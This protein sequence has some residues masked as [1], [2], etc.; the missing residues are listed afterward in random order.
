M[1]TNNPDGGHSDEL[2][3]MENK[4]SK[5]RSQVNSKLDN[6][7]HL[8]VILSAVE[9]NLQDQKTEKTPVAYFVSFCSLLDQSISNDFIV[10][11]GLA[12]ASSYFLD[13]VLPFT[14]KPL[15]VSKFG[16]ILAKL[17]VPITSSDAEAPLV[18]S[19]IGA[20]ES[21][22]LAQDYQRWTSNDSISPQRAMAGLLE[23]T[24]D[25]RPKVRRRAQEAVSS[26]LKNPPTSPNPMHPASTLCGKIALERLASILESNK[27][28]H[29][30]EVN[31]QIIHCLQ[32]IS[33]V[34]SSGSWP[35]KQIMPLCD[36]LLEVSKTNDQFIV[37][38]AFSAFEGLF[39][40]MNNVVN[41]ER[42]SQ[43]LDVIFD[44]KPAVNDLH[45]AASWLAV[46]AKASECFAALDAS[47]YITKFSNIFHQVAAFLSSESKD[48]YSS[49]SHCL[50]AITAAIPDEYLLQ[51][52]KQ[53]GISPEV[54]ESMDD[55]ISGLADTIEKDLLT[56]KHQHAFKEILEFINES[57][58]KLRS[59]AN[60]DLLGIVE[61][62]GDWRTTES[63][64]FS[65]NKEA[66][67]VLAS[68]ISVMGPEVV[69]GVLPLN[70][71]STT[72]PGRAWLL[73]LLRDNVRFANLGFYI[74]EILPL[75]EFF[76]EKISNL[77]KDSVNVKIFQT[78]IDQ[79][80]SLLPPFC[81]LP[82]DLTVAF[83]DSFA[84][85]LTEVLYSNVESRA[86]ICN[87]LRTLAESYITYS[88]EEL[89]KD[90]LAQE[91]LSI[92]QATVGLEY[93]ASK[94]SNVLSVLFNIFSSTSPDSRGFILETID[95][96]LMI[97]PK[98]ELENTFNKVC[99]LLKN[100]MDEESTETQT[101]KKNTPSLSITMMDLIVAMAKYVPSSSH[102]ALFSI[103]SSTIS[104]KN[105]L[106]QKRSYRILTKLGEVSEGQNSIKQFA[107][108]IANV[109]I[110]TIDD[111]QSSARATRLGAVNDLIEILPND[112][113]HFIPAVLQEIIMCTKDANERTRSL[114]YQVLIRMGEK[115]EQGGVI[116]N[117]K[118]PGFD[119]ATPDSEA[120]LT[121]FFTMVS[122]G[123]AAQSPH[124]VSATITAVSCLV[125]EFKDKLPTDVL[126]ELCST[127]E[128]F[129][130]HNSREIAKSTIGFVKV[131][132]LS[133]PEELVKANL[134]EL[135]SKLM[136]WSH[137]H[138]GHFKVKVKHIVERLIRKFGYDE[139]EQA[140]PEEDR[141]LV[142]NIKKT[143]T[144]AKRKQ[145]EDGT[146][147]SEK[148]G[149]KFVSA[150]EE[151]LYDSDV[152]DNDDSEDEVDTQRN[153]KSSQFI[154][155]SRD[156]PLDLL[157]RQAFAKI[158]SSK[159]R[160]EVKRNYSERAETK[161]GKF[162][163]N[164]KATSDP[165]SNKGSGIDAYLDAVK[166][167]PIR[168][169]KNRMKF[170]KD[171]ADDDWSDDDEPPQETHHRPSKND[172]FKGNAR[173]SKPKPKQKFKAKK[174][175]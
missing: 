1:A 97:V 18:R 94:A 148:Q 104:S 154:M 100:A 117:S 113:L 40:S 50:T 95:I 118:V 99:G 161:N 152:S 130:T 80:W 2:F 96:Y 87:A 29:N 160:K 147:A 109:I 141:K 125:F 6:Q 122:G 66:E 73:P 74:S 33:S 38:S 59:R 48:I 174:K 137:Q 112:F 72:S 69:L 57:I 102:T 8:A 157:D 63:E 173:I 46:V 53:N 64:D 107:N 32:L 19:T 126:V 131:E 22:L 5:I 44:L 115:M 110:S 67:D 108:D 146:G 7:K 145:K 89:S 164:E 23:L 133:L 36:V 168:G 90:L 28:K 78:I 81:D 61:T 16:D 165:L 167:G 93:L 35:A 11:Q 153:K 86:N 136:R 24:M 27:S 163:F 10:D 98:D 21:L 62:I 14:A 116:S 17:A 123:L 135:L 162:V 144:R 55:L 134:G 54:Y 103:F 20:L 101:K 92:E 175:L 84:S 43:V 156:S 138:T 34:T 56:I 111:T 71:N 83:T 143:R 88:D 172:K 75:V 85:Q 51:P 13:I 155:E 3:E 150:Y 58:L 37:S 9:E 132:V 129:L 82:K 159:P 140:I 47:V 121:E 127:V 26:I 41:L 49:A 30:K 77:N 91:E 15:L 169:Q 142:A 60:P 170:K 139:V 25:H 31:A 149:K 4:L 158:S 45:L 119:P 39:Q 76:Q 114:S 70:L 120:N 166:Q 124:M 12:T 105:P 42:F 65:H 68:A 52:S 128:L 79:I 106:M 151:A 171:N